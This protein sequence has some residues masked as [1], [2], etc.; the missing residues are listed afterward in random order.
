MIRPLYSFEPD[1]VKLMKTEIEDS[2]YEAVQ[3][4]GR[5][6]Q[7]GGIENIALELHPT[8]LKLRGRSET[9]ILNFLGARGCRRQP[10]Y[11]NLVLSRF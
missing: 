1:P 7:R 5:I 11:K 3:G 2:E 8:I 6:F 10:E 9:E 4:S